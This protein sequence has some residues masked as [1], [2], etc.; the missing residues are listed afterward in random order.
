MNLPELG[1]CQPD[2]SV[3]GGTSPWHWP[4]KFPLQDAARLSPPNASLFTVVRDPYTRSVSEFYCKFQGFKGKPEDLV[5]SSVFNTWIQHKIRS[6]QG[7]KNWPPP[8]DNIRFYPQ[9]HFVYNNDTQLIPHVLHYEKLQTEFRDLMEQYG[10]DIRLPKKEEGGD[11]VNLHKHKL[12]V[13]NLTTETIS[14][15]NDY[16]SEDFHKFGYEKMEPPSIPE[17]SEQAQPQKSQVERILYLNL[18]KNTKRNDLMKQWLQDDKVNDLG[19]P[20]SRI[21]AMAGK[22]NECVNG[23][24][25]A[26]C[27]GVAGLAQTLLKILDD[28]LPGMTLVFED[29]YHVTKPLSN[30]IEKTLKHVPSNWDIIRFDCDGPIRSSFPVIHNGT[31]FVVFRANHVNKCQESS[32]TFC[33]G[34][35][36]QLWRDSSLDRLK[37]VWSSRPFNDVDCRLV[38][39]KEF[40]GYCVNMKLGQLVRLQGE[41]SDITHIPDTPAQV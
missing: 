11:N 39:K 4:P 33:G 19:I 21:E 41:E 23:I 29:D 5:N 28:P 9:H 1:C 3:P 20:Y 16:F 30:A 18:A 36:A 37:D 27:R 17:S 22:D 15:I 25:P 2:L 12:T 40:I 32:C 8:T 10:L 13:A 26:R 38:W 6:R 24:D 31:D 35:H 7:Q 34:T 14:L